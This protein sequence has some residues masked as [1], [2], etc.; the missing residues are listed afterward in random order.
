MDILVEV[1]LQAEH[2]GEIA[3]ALKKQLGFLA[4]DGLSVTTE[5]RE[6]T[7]ALG[8]HEVYLFILHHREG[9]AAIAAVAAGVVRL[10]D[11]VV[12]AVRRKY[13]PSPPPKTKKK[14]KRKKSEKEPKPP[15]PVT[16]DAAELSLRFPASAA[17]RRAFLNGIRRLADEQA[18]GE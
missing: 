14:A 2:A 1:D 17:K 3:D 10:I 13:P 5:S 12:T 4:G 7:G 11:A 9:I 8:P 18:D 15:N 16:V 6:K